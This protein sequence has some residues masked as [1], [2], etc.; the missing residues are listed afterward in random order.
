MKPRTIDNVCEKLQFLAKNQDH[1]DLKI[2]LINAIELVRMNQADTALSQLLPCRCAAPTDDM[3]RCYVQ[4]IEEIAYLIIYRAK[5]LMTLSTLSVTLDV[6][7]TEKI[8]SA[9]REQE[10]LL[11]QMAS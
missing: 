8:S 6:W 2:D 11:R 5:T 3:R 10:R 9:L 7:V 1:K 4:A